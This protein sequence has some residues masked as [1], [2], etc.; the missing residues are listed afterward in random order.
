MKPRFTAIILGM[1]YLAAGLLASL[2]H[3]HHD[4]SNT[5][6]RDCAACVWQLNAAT[7]VPITVTV[8]WTVAVES[9]V[10]VPAAIELPHFLSLASASRAPPMTL[11]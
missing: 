6:D 1:L 9:P 7:D 4:A 3:H 10:P 11:V 2:G 5:P 8:I